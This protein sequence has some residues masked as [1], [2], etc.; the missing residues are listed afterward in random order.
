MR[1]MKQILAI[2]RKELD[3]YFGSPM[4]L[5]F[6]GL[7]LV[8]V[9][10]SFFWVSGFFGRGIA[11]IRPLFEWMPVLLILL[12]STLTMRQWSE[13]QQTGTLEMLLTT[14]VRLTQ[15]VI[16]KFL[17]VLALVCVAL[18]LTLSLPITVSQLGNLAL[19]PVVGGYLGAILMASAYIAIGLFVSSR[20]DN[21]IVSL[22][23]TPIVCGLFFLVGSSTVTAFANSN[24]SDFLRALGT[25]SRFES[26]ER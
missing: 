2:T 22:M 23:I 24:I 21:Q 17:A 19:G 6:V 11:D 3:S 18:A 26:I 13:E 16:G 5:I 25:G 20:T 9:R 4:A 7:F 1:R 10:F 14:P 8:T 12:I 15:L